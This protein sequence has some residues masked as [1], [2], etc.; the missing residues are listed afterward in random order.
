MVFFVQISHWFGAT[1]CSTYWQQCYRVIGCPCIRSSTDG[2]FGEEHGNSK[3]IDG[4][5][6]PDANLPWQWPIAF[7][8]GQ[9]REYFEFAPQVMACIQWS[10]HTEC[11][12]R[13][14]SEMDRSIGSSRTA[15]FLGNLSS[16]P[17][18]H[19]NESA[20]SEESEGWGVNDFQWILFKTQQFNCHPKGYNT[21]NGIWTCLD[22]CLNKDKHDALLFFHLHR[23]DDLFSF[24][25]L[26]IF[27]LEIKILI[28]E[29]Q[30]LERQ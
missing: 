30:P 4:G 25:I 9:T 21:Q 27:V 2:I 19:P 8:S 14:P 20:V 13:A 24:F 28:D 6:W 17:A 1:W 18:Y 12:R 10:E 11:F 29:W 7:H 22:R 23:M 5:Q 3:H 16:P 26:C 15:T